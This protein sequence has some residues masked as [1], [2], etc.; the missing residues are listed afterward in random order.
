MK[1]FL[2]GAWQALR[3][4]YPAGTRLFW[5]AP[6]IPALVIVPEFMQHVVEVKLGMFESKDV[7]KALQNDPMRWNFA[8]AKIAGL[9]LAILAS[10][11]FWGVRHREGRWW[12]VRDICWTPLLLGL[13]IFGGLGS[14]PALWDGQLEPTVDTTLEILVGLITLP[15]LLLIVGGL[16]GDPLP[17]ARTL[18]LR[19]WPYLLLIVVL[20]AIGFGPAAWVHQKNHVWAMGLAPFPLWAIMVWD[21]LLVGF[22]ACLAGTA[23]ALGYRL[24]AEN[25]KRRH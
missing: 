9:W 11:R 1:A 21:S 8:Y 4:L 10:A 23:V 2:I 19:S 5:L 24:F 25:S 6:L 18:V 14:L 13:A 15:G 17:R 12:D 7:F 22:L 20:V 3:D 16:F